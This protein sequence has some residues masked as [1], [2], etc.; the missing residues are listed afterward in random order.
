MR[1]CLGFD[2]LFA[3][4]L[5][6]SSASEADIRY[7]NDYSVQTEDFIKL[8][9][10]IT[11][12][13]AKRKVVLLIDETDQA[14]NNQVFLHFLGMLREK[15]LA[16]KAAEDFTF[17]SVILA[18]VYD[19]KNIKLR[20]IEKGYVSAMEGEVKYNSPWNIAAQ[21]DVDLSFS[22]KEISSMLA[23]YETDHPTGMNI[24][25]IASGIIREGILF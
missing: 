17:H 9:E 14:S 3:K 4:S 23:E 19:V 7:W 13:C 22:V 5:R 2:G 25:A 6:F 8:S 15:Y 18:G 12:F 1:F 11:D 20:M 21:F 24:S 10:K 16:R